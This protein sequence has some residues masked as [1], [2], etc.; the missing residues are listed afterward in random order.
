MSNQWQIRTTA[1]LGDSSPQRLARARVAVLGLGGVGGA[2]AEGLVRAGVGHLLLIDKDVFDLSNLNRQ[3]L[4]DLSLVG[5]PKIEGA[6][7]R[8]SSINPQAELTLK[9]E[10]YLPENSGFLWEFQPDYVVD[11][12]DTV[13]AKLH[14][15]QTCCE[16]GIPLLT[17]LGT[18]NRLDPSRLTV[19][20]IS[21]TA[22]ISC[23]LARVMRRELKKR[24]VAQLET[25]YSTE[26]PAKTIVD[27]SHGRHSPGSSPFVPPAA[28]YLM[29]SVVVRRLCGLLPEII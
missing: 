28:G 15:A 8:F 4:S 25:V 26:V 23:P 18:G 20:D 1:L 17:C 12:I 13:T 21:Q 3:I 14:L 6:L 22:G 29:A 9:Q 19:G 27:D 7:R 24:G 16:K 10:F 2:A 5:Q 11:A